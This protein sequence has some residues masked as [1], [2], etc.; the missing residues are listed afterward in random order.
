MHQSGFLFDS[1]PLP[2]PLVRTKPA[3]RVRKFARKPALQRE[4]YD[5]QISLIFDLDDVLPFE[6]E[7]WCNTSVDQLYG[8]L[9]KKTLAIFG[10]GRASLSSRAEAFDWLMS[11][12]VFPF[13]FRTCCD[14]EGLNYELTR[15]LTVDV[16]RRVGIK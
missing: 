5:S 7:D 14:I 12:E 13:S 11:D 10:D 15:N 1:F 2:N 4:V 16:I 8:Y 9:L 6:D 3:L